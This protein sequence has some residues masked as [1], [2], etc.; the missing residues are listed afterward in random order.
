MGKTTAGSGL[1]GDVQRRLA[2]GQSDAAI[3]AEL[4]ASGL[5]RPSAERFLQRARP[6]DAPAPGVPALPP[7]IPLVEPPPS[8]DAT[9]LHPPS[10]PAAPKTPAASAPASPLA[11]LSVLGA[12]ATLT[13]GL[14][15]VTWG[16][17]QERNVRLRLP[18]V[19]VVTGG[20]WLL[21]ASRR[22]VDPRRP[23]TWLVPAAAAMPPLLAF[24]V[25][26]GTLAAGRPRPEAQTAG[27]GPSALAVVSTTARPAARR[28]T[29]PPT[30]DERIAQSVDTLEGTRPGDRCGAAQA[31]AQS[32]AR[33][34]ASLLERHLSDVTAHTEKICLA[35][36]LTQLGGGDVTVSHYLEWSG[37]DED[38]LRHHAIV[39]FGHLGPGAASA[40]LPVLE[41]IVEGGASAARRYVVVTTL[42]RLGPAAR[43]LLQ[44]LA[45]DDDAQVQAAAQAALR[46][47]P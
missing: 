10:L 21:Q 43:P 23:V 9:A 24:V 8:A 35:H 19:I 36:A 39:G 37:S 32:G 34:H 4:T 18:L 38:L 27:A 7:P 29:R 12:A 40:T 1:L 47:L 16:L 15:A 17:S 11:W 5:S 42:A 2:L 14:A 25:V 46:S 20:A 13:F 31:L 30:R 3:L 33:E 26:L 45:R 28:T 22:V 6:A 41:R 44:T